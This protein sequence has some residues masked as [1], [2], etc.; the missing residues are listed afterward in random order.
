MP[1]CL[2]G[3][4]SNLGDRGGTLERA[5]EELR[6]RAQIDVVAVSRWYETAPI[7]GPAAQD[8]YLNGAA[9]LRTTLPPRQMLGRLA[10][11]E[12]LLGR[13]RS[14]RWQARTLDLDLLLYDDIILNEP[15]LRIP[16]PRMAFRRFVLVGA[17]QIAPRMVHPIMGWTVQRLLEH[18]DKAAPYVAITGLAGCGKTNLAKAV[19]ERFSARLIEQSPKVPQATESNQTSICREDSTGQAWDREIE[20]LLRRTKSLD[21]ANW[22]SAPGLSVSD[23]WFDQSMAFARSSLP[24]DL[25]EE[26]RQRWQDARRSVTP[27]KLLVMLSASP[28]RVASG[29]PFGTQQGVVDRMHAVQTWLARQS[30]QSDVGPVLYLD[31]ADPATARAETVAAVAAMK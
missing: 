7:G 5:V 19:A 15:S 16:H 12:T 24:G 25:F 4:G 9:L 23:F 14:E 17:A 27:P 8:P 26:F 13:E 1:S 10:R 31:A 20:F 30:G 3:L 21:R 11:I 28:E 2:I 18:L 6:R 22:P 29:S